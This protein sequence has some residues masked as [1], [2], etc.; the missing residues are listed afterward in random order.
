MNSVKLKFM[1]H[2]VPWSVYQ[3]TRWNINFIELKKRD[4]RSSLPIEN[5]SKVEVA[6]GVYFN[7]NRSMREFTFNGFF[8]ASAA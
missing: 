7:A 6:I 1:K 2:K 4:F 5:L 8:V 3:G